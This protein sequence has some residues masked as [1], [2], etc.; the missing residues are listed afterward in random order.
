[1]TE[2][3]HSKTAS[4]RPRIGVSAC[5]LG[6]KV[7]YDGGHKHDR[8]VTDVLGIW[9]EFVPVCPEVE[10]GLGTPRPTIRLE[11]L[12]GALRLV[13]P[14][15]GSDHTTAMNTFAEKRSAALAR[16]HLCGYILKKDSPSCG[17]ERVRVYDR[18]GVPARDGRGLFAA[19][20]VQ[21]LPSLPVEEEGR[22]ND[23]R[24]RE[25]FVT[26][27]FAHQRWIEIE[28]AG[29][30]R[31]R[32]FRFHERH[33]YVLMAH[34]QAGMRRLGHLLGNA[35]KRTDVAGLA[36]EYLES[37][38][39]AMQRVPTPKN[40]ANVLQHIAGYFSDALDPGDR[41]EL[42]GTIDDY[43]LGRLPLVVPVT[44]VR[45]HVRRHQV[46]YLLDQVYLSP[47]PAELM[48]LNH[49]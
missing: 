38:T 48:L 23:P 10:I 46:P 13:C 43:R 6:Q 28:R 41:A 31:A 30:T 35:S 5:L 14:T 21:R 25:N 2:P 37:F 49:V 11:R 12:G 47:H 40:H 33:K 16:A 15:S 17:L 29:I 9:V 34:S 8:W 32:L 44:L 4:K 20:L 18:N 42:A 36:D 27:I 26:R 24:L 1:M 7:R 39:A 3:A 22:L 19:A 45:H